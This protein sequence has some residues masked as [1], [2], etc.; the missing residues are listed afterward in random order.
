MGPR[1]PPPFDFG[2]T[3]KGRGAGCL[4]DDPL[5]RLA[6]SLAF[7]AGAWGA[8]PGFWDSFEQLAVPLRDDLPLVFGLELSTT[9]GSREFRIPG[10]IGKLS[11]RLSEPMGIGGVHSDPCPRLLDDPVDFAS[12]FHGRD[13]WDSQ[14]HDPVD[15]AGDDA[16]PEPGGEGDRVE[17]RR[18][19]E[20]QGLLLRAVGD[21]RD[22]GESPELSLTLERPTGCPVP[23][24]DESN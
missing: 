8:C 24:D 7:A 12:L 19:Q 10:A 18:C 22:V 1:F 9:T 4:D 3:G 14:G 2:N 13:E 16:A 21:E 5:R 11:D 15:L 20:A 17:V 6:G 23:Q